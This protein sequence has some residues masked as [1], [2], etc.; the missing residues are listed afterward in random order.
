MKRHLAWF[1]AHLMVFQ[2]LGCSLAAPGTQSIAI[3]PSHPKADVYVD[4]VQIGTGTVTAVLSRENSHTV[5]AK[6]PGS[7]GIFTIQRGLST[8]GLLDVVG[9]VLILVPFIGLF[10]PGAFELSPPTAAVAIPD[11]SG[12]DEGKK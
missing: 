9:G 2:S 3:V 11:E 4:G 8:M 7:S 10:S 12:C 6:C 5:M 1:L